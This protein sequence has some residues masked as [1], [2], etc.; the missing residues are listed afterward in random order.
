VPGREATGRTV[1]P[2]GASLRP[3][4]SLCQAVS[5]IPRLRFPRGSSADVPFSGKSTNRVRIPVTLCGFSWDFADVQVSLCERNLS[6]EQTHDEWRHP[7][8]DCLWSCG[9][10]RP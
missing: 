8:G 5:T 7:V 6:N 1:P 9:P 4:V 3:T 2:G 10:G